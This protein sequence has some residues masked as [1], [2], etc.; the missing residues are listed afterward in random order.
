MGSRPDGYLVAQT[1]ELFIA[2]A[3]EIKTAG[4]Y[5]EFSTVEGEPILCLVTDDMAEKL[6][7]TGAVWLDSKDWFVG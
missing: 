4:T 2:K 1:K 3:R 6:K 7:P 5:A